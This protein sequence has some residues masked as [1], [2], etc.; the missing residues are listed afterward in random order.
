MFPNYFDFTV[1][2]SAISLIKCFG[3]EI[4]MKWPRSLAV[5]VHFFGE[6]GL[7]W[8]TY[9]FRTISIL[10]YDGLGNQ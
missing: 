9:V 2:R 5:L 3:G 10:Q 8:K 4:N 7:R 1:Q 6:K